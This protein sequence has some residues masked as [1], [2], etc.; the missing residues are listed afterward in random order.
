MRIAGVISQLAEATTMVTITNL[1]NLI[2][3][4]APPST[5]TECLCKLA[6]SLHMFTPA[7]SSPC[8]SLHFDGS[9]LFAPEKIPPL[10]LARQSSLAHQQ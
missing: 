3:P 5:G 10:P 7:S 9:D 8:A 2:I 1:E 6:C 4:P